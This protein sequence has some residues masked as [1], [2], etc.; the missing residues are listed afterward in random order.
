MIQRVDGPPSAGA[1]VTGR[2]DGRR[3]GALPHSAQQ[4]VTFGTGLFVGDGS[5]GSAGSA[6]PDTMPVS[7]WPR[8]RFFGHATVAL[9]TSVSLWP[10]QRSLHARFVDYFDVHVAN[11]ALTWP[12]TP[13]QT[14]PLRRL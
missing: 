2:G 5:R 11:V 10:R 6:G 3:T 7:L 14:R 9:A 4:L 8:H 1:P 12:K 13:A